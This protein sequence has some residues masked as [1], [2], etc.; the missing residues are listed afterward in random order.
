MPRRGKL[1]VAAALLTALLCLALYASLPRRAL[2]DGELS[3]WYLEGECP[4]EAMQTLLTRFERE[5][6]LRAAPRGFPDG[7]SLADA[8]EDGRPALLWCSHLRAE[9]IAA[10]GGLSASAALAEPRQPG[11]SAALDGRFA[12]VGA[13]LPVLVCDPAR[14]PEPPETLEALL[15]LDGVAADSWAELLYEAALS[16]GVVLTGDWERD[17]RGKHFAALYNALASACFEGRLVLTENALES[18]RRG[19]AVCALVDPVSLVPL[20]D[21]TLCLAPLPLPE[22]GRALRGAVV[23]GFA[24]AG[25]GESADAF[26]AWLAGAEA[27]GRLALDAGLA[28]LGRAPAGTGDAECA[29]I[30]LGRSESLRAVPAGSWSEKRAD[31]E[32][33][34]RERL[35]LLG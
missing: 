21:A 13:R 27:G 33:A 26:L 23:M 7:Q 29:L 10:L 25:G 22:R 5:S 3:V 28:P 9:R 16:R 18:L 30:A 1:I 14:L 4:P 19:E 15:E 24:V 20:G 17:S 34:L 11:L 8:L 35:R 31:M 2:S 6:G 32:A 12:P